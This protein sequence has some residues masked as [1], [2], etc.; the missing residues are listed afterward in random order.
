M[1]IRKN[2]NQVKEILS[3]NNLIVEK[4]TDYSNKSTM[5]ALNNDFK[6]LN[7]FVK[8]IE[9]NKSEIMFY[10]HS[11]LCYTVSI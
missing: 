6:L 11:N 9:I 7:S 5:T 3:N 2:S 4:I 10:F 8:V 1:T